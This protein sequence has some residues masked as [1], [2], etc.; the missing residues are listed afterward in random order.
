MPTLND[1][2]KALGKKDDTWILVALEF[3]DDGSRQQCN[4]TLEH[5]GIKYTIDAMNHQETKKKFFELALHLA[6]AA[7]SIIADSIQAEK[8]ENGED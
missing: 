7:R 6:E 2:R 8:E 4:V 1:L 3:S 5:K